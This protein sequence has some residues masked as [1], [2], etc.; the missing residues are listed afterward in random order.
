[1]RFCK[2]DR[3]NPAFHRDVTTSLRV[4]VSRDDVT[5][6]EIY[7]HLPRLAREPPLQYVDRG[8]PWP[9]SVLL[10]GLMKG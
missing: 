7:Q 9:G 3:A 4:T 2:S 10:D 5:W 1:M 8:D 6:A